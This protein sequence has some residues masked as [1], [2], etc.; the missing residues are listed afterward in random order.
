VFTFSTKQFYFAMK[1]AKKFPNM[2]RY[3]L[4]WFC[5]SDG[6]NTLSTASVLFATTELK[7]NTT[8]AGFLVLE[9]LF[10]GSWGGIFFLWL[11]RKIHWDAKQMLLLHI[12]TFI[13][14]CLWSMLG[15]FPSLPF[16]LKNKAELY[17]FGFV[18]G[19]NWGSIQSY[20]RSVFAYLVPIGKESQ[21]FALYEITDK[22]SSWIGPLLVGFI[23]TH[24]SIRWGML[25]VTLFFLI[26]AP[27]LIWGVQLKTGMIQ[28]GRWR[29]DDPENRHNLNSKKLEMA[30]KASDHRKADNYY[31][32]KVKI[33]VT[34][35]DDIEENQK[36][37]SKENNA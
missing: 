26:A 21:M 35:P 27:L 24:Y 8:E 33:T 31:N 14:L 10:L 15:L 13:I 9:V 25:Y 17:V 22:G 3:L 23:T 28:A 4:S 37:E 20:A 30:N 1:E 2:F 5:F 29:D 32:P 36:E 12:G 16:G 19:M 6:L 11:Q 7:M 18:Y 34:S